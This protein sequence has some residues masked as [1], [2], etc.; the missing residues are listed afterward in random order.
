MNGSLQLTD[1]VHQQF[2]LGWAQMH[3][4]TFVRVA[5]FD[6]AHFVSRRYNDP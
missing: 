1:K 2:F 5:G 3:I 6:S 4:T